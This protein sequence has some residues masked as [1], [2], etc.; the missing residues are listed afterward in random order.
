MKEKIK[1]KDNHEEGDGSTIERSI[2]ELESGA[3][4][5]IL[6]LGDDETRKNYQDLFDKNKIQF[7]AECY[8]IEQG[9]EVVSKTYENLESFLNKDKMFNANDYSDEEHIKRELKD[10][11]LSETQKREV[12]IE[13][14]GLL[15]SDGGYTTAEATTEAT[16]SV[17]EIKV[18]SIR[19]EFCLN[20]GITQVNYDDHK[21]TVI[22]TIEIQ[23]DINIDVYYRT[24]GYAAYFET[25]IFDLKLEKFSTQLEGRYGSIQEVL[26]FLKKSKFSSI[27]NIHKQTKG[28]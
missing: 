13:A 5:W 25:F 19:T 9:Y 3:M 2:Q 11:P 6:F 26:D 18:N 23:E 27:R 14:L 7:I 15:D 16:F 1:L 8:E 10:T 4:D 12:I 17:E 20:D 24:T 28:K 21:D 22:C